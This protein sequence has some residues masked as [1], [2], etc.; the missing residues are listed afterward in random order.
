MFPSRRP[1]I[2]I[3]LTALLLTS[4][5]ACANSP[6]ARNLEQSLAADPNLQENPVTVGQ[7]GSDRN[8]QT[9]PTVNL[10]SD[11][12]SEINKYP[13]AQLQEVKLP[14]STTPAEQATLTRWTSGDPVNLVQNFYQKQFQENNWQLLSQPTDDAGGT[15]EAKR[16]DLK[17]TVSI[18]PISSTTNTS[19]T[20]QPAA[21]QNSAA[22]TEFTIQYER[23]SSDTAQ[24]PSGDTT[25]TAPQ[26]EATS[27]ASPTPTPSAQPTATSQAETATNTT[28]N[29]IVFSDLNN[30][31]KELRSYVTDV[32][33]LG[34]L[35]L[36]PPNS[37][38]NQSAAN[39]KFEPN[40]AISHREFAR[41][42]I[43]TSNKMNANNPAKQIRL[44]TDASQPAFQDVP[45]TDPDFAAIQGLAEAGI[46]PSPLS[47]DS[48]AVLFRP[49]A[50][51]TREQLLMWKV[52]LDTRLVSAATID[53]VKQTWGFQDVAKIDP[54]ALRSILT[55]FQNGDTSIIRRVFG[56]TTLFQPKKSVTR[57]EAA[58]AL[59]YFGTQNEGI[60]AK[61]LVTKE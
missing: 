61:E 36:N 38:Q 18:Q 44:A 15:F 46:I 12:P 3:N 21:N 27:S 24:Q 23:V 39:T 16:N 8:V 22:A 52:P 29:V 60:S 14:N 45:K 53:S 48:T 58:A 50:A 26:P 10:P 57:A 2:L 32:A 41:W 59:W 6:A 42:L 17:V 43:A 37:K 35:T 5:T 33:Q 40:K 9:S 34:V 28:N 25:A 31:P 20:N 7:S 1:A 19:S 13:L 56:Y 49:G 47:G 4:L 54:K 55:D 51:L 11:F 30:A